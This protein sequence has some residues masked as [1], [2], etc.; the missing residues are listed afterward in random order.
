[1]SDYSSFSPSI[2]VSSLIDVTCLLRLDDCR[3]AELVSLLSVPL[4]LPPLCLRHYRENPSHFL[5]RQS[6]S[7]RKLSD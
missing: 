5:V 6:H 7:G 3:E 1:M 2:A 4:T